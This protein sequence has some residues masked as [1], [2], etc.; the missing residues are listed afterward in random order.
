MYD[1]SVRKEVI[2]LRVEDK[3]SFPEIQKQTK[4]SKGTLSLW[5]KPYPLPEGDLLERK[6]RNGSRFGKAQADLKR[7]PISQPSKLWSMAAS[8]KLT[9]DQKGRIAETAILLRLVV[10][11]FNPLRSMFEGSRS[12]WVVE[13]ANT[14]RVI[15][16]QVKWA[17]PGKEGR[18]VVQTTTSRRHGRYSYSP[19]DFDFLIGYD[20]RTDTAH[21][22]SWDDIKGRSRSVSVGKA[23]EEAWHKIRV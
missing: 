10:L 23:S 9:S 16:L 2:R 3:L 17:S 5:L 7:A 8:N 13:V 22:F 19:K 11:G 6:R 21:V 15:R 18:P 14:D 4:L 1:V 12:D 20:L